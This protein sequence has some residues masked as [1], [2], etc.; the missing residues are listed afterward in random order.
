MILLNMKFTTGVNMTQVGFLFQGKYSNL[1]ADWYINIGSIIIM[2]M[3]FNISF[4]IIELILTNLL[5]CLKHCW[6]RKFGCRKTSCK[7]KAEY[8]KLFSHD[9]YP[10]E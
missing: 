10:I 9:V 7:T 2:T 3:I 6:D 4:P 5:K 1:A 8:I